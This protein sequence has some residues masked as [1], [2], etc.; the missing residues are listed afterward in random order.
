MGE[1]R[2]F[3]EVGIIIK[4]GAAGFTLIMVKLRGFDTLVLHILRRDRGFPLI[5]AKD[6]GFDTVL[7]PFVIQ[8]DHTEGLGGGIV[9]FSTM[10]S[11][12]S[13]LCFFSESRVRKDSFRGFRVSIRHA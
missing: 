11:I 8:Y 1:N 3:N 10:F 9:L 13:P 12:F 2:G 5:S 7:F 4:K 6:M